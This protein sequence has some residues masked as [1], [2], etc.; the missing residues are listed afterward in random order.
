MTKLIVAFRNVA[1]AP[2]I[3]PLC[4][5]IYIYMPF[6]L[7]CTTRRHTQQYHN[8]DSYR[9][10]KLKAREEIYFVLYVL[11]YVTMHCKYEDKSFCT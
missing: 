2:K 8:I 4:P 3:L 1:N 9:L 7:K 6:P 11:S 5:Y 10:D